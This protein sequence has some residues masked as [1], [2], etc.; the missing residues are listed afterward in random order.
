MT[1][2]LIT[3]WSEYDRAVQEVLDLAP[4][5]LQIFDQ[6]LSPLQLER[7]QRLAALRDLL[8]TREDDKQLTIIV[9]KPDFVRQYSPR[10]LH[11]L[12][13]YAPAL[14]ITQSPAHLDAL[15][16]SL[17]IADRRH[18]LVRFH[19]D[20]ARARLM[21]DDR[22]ECAPYLLRFEEILAAGGEPLSPTTLG[23]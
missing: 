18:A 20:H 8:A 6:D 21:V 17:L 12:T 14:T 2:R 23:L 1:S 4:R 13:V 10:L 22:K 15:Q 9:Q 19:R 16:D 11:L 3:T 5:V 7:P